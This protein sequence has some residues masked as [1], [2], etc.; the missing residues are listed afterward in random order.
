MTNLV[1]MCTYV[2]KHTESDVIGLAQHLGKSPKDVMRAA[3]ERGLALIMQEI[4]QAANYLEIEN[5][6]NI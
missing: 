3:L 2:H 4:A 6:N 1:K 5:D